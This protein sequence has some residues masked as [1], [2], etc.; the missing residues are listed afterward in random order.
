MADELRF[1][2]DTHISKQVA[3]Q[4]RQRAI[5][6]IR[7]EEV[8]MAEAS[9][10]AHLE[11]A[12]EQGRIL[13]TVDKGFRDRA[14]NWLAQGRKHGGV[15]IIHPDLQGLAGIGQIVS[16]CHFFHQAVELGAASEDEFKDKVNYIP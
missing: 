11:Y 2:A 8:G 10:E 13:L 1:Y 5:D 3:L 9:D 16:W 7:C 14:F 15:I 12:T 4:L 6:I